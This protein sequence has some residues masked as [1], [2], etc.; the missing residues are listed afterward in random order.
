MRR[1]FVTVTLS[2][3]KPKKWKRPRGPGRVETQLQLQIQNST[4]KAAHTQ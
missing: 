1:S 3:L 4:Q 2:F